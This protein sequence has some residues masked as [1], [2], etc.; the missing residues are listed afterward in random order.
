MKTEAMRLTG[1]G[2][3]ERQP[4]D[5]YKTP[6]WAINE[7]LLRERF[8]S[9]V[10]DPACGD[11][12]ITL[13]LEAFGPEY[14]AEQIKAS[15]I[16]ETPDIRGVTGVDFLNPPEW[17]RQLA[18]GRY[19]SI[20][21]NPPFHLNL[22]FILQ[23]LELVDH[24]LAVFGRIQLLESKERYEQL[25]VPHPPARV[26]VFSKRVSCDPNGRAIMSFAWYLWDK[27]HKGL[28]TLHWIFPGAVKQEEH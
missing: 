25:W 9:P 28:P 27:D 15:D 4:D 26:Y 10:Y 20:V 22:P 7:L 8:P 2:D 19:G 3:A 1:D 18:R 14:R 11:G 12:A 24:K 17:A 13:A 23:A 6:T 21:M 16:R 5:F